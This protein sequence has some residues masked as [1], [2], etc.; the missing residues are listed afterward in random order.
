M[1]CTV[2][3]NDAIVMTLHNLAFVDHIHVFLCFSVYSVYVTKIKMA[4][5]DVGLFEIAN[6]W[7]HHREWVE[8]LINKCVL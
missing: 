3:L 2:L 4:N 6:D 7:K 1:H 5:T 8:L